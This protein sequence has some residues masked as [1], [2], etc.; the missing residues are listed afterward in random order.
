MFDWLVALVNSH[1]T[2]YGMKL[3]HLAELQPLK[4]WIDES[5]PLLSSPLYSMPTKV[6]W[7][8]NGYTDF[9]MCKLCGKPVG[10]NKNVSSK[11]GYAAH[12]SVNCRN[13]DPSEIAQQVNTLKSHV[14]EDP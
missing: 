11:R 5:L 2:G 1:P 7:I 6:C 10:V 14:H 4:Q 3:K 13:H 9:P 8:A 12:C